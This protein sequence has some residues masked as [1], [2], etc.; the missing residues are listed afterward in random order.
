M[1]NVEIDAQ[2]FKPDSLVIDNT[3]NGLIGIRD[4]E[5]IQVPFGK[6]IHCITCHTYVAGN[7]QNVMA[8]LEST[9]MS[10]GDA[11]DFEVD[12][13]S[14]H[15]I[16]MKQTITGNTCY[17]EAYHISRKATDF[18]RDTAF[19]L[20]LD[21]ECDGSKFTVV[22]NGSGNGKSGK[23][24]GSYTCTSGDLP[25]SWDA[26]AP[27]LQQGF[28][29]F[30]SVPE[31]VPNFYIECMK[32][33]GYTMEQE[34]EFVH[35]TRSI[36]ASHNIRLES[37]IVKN[38]VTMKAEGFKGNNSELG[39]INNHMNCRGMLNNQLRDVG[40][41]TLTNHTFA[42]VAGKAPTLS[43]LI[44]TDKPHDGV[45]VPRPDYLQVDIACQQHMDAKTFVCEVE[46][47]ATI[48]TTGTKQ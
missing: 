45:V 41:C 29:M 7:G 24:R 31:N 17:Q 22:G 28:K 26:I 18:L 9:D 13:V 15:D 23:S 14:V 39:Y 42:S 36:T 11:G 33:G 34:M 25:M 35:D 30:M 8:I 48:D 38:T 1:S 4:S 47:V 27:L 10:D 19:R 6:G 32:T 2:G 46:Q 44:S 16:A 37:G 12:D 43:M 5:Q 3:G 21:G 20:E 40:V